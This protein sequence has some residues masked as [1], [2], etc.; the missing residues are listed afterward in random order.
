MLVG[1]DGVEEGS[2]QERIR[3]VMEIVVV[4]FWTVPALSSSGSCLCESV[5]S[6]PTLFIRAVMR[7]LTLPPFAALRM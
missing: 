1:V 6:V 3:P 7:R 2:F 5:L 4:D